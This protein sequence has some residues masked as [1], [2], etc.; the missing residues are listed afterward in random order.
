[1][2]A[3]EHRKGSQVVERSTTVVD[4]I[5]NAIACAQERAKALA[6][7]NIRVSNSE[8]RAIGVFPV[9]RESLS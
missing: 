5:D 8:G 3:I 9:R 2:F 1:M 6:A 4:N 7:D